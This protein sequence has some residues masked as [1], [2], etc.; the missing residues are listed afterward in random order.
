MAIFAQRLPWTSEAH[1]WRRSTSRFTL[2]SEPRSV[3]LMLSTWPIWHR[4]E[5][6]KQISCSTISVLIPSQNVVPEKS[7]TV[8]LHVPIMYGLRLFQCNNQLFPVIRITDSSL[9]C[10]GTFSVWKSVYALDLMEMGL[11]AGCS[12]RWWFQYYAAVIR[13]LCDS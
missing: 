11:S 2:R 8:V 6:S 9:I 5:V 4:A 10:V 1:A 3:R 12:V 13:S 7:H